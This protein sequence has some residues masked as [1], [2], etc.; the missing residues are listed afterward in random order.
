MTVN[1]LAGALREE[2][3]KNH[4]VGKRQEEVY[5]SVVFVFFHEEVCS[6]KKFQKHSHHFLGLFFINSDDTTVPQANFSDTYNPSVN[7]PTKNK[8]KPKSRK[9]FCA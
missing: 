9:A 8:H 2:E 1:Y 4:H 7:S 5:A 3:P 6:E